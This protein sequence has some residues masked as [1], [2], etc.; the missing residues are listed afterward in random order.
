[1]KEEQLL[2]RLAEEIN[3]VLRGAQGYGAGQP[4][5]PHQGHPPLGKSEVQRYIDT[6]DELDNNKEKDTKQK[7]KVSKAFRNKN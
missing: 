7:V 3:L 4:W 5:S 1:M 2:K 6:A